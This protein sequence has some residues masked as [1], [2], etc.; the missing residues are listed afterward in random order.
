[1]AKYN[2]RLF[3]KSVDTA[4]FSCG[5][6]ELD[7]YICRYASQDLKRNLARVFIATPTDDSAQLAG[8]YTLSAGSVSC[9]EIPEALAKTLPKYPVPVALLGRLAINTR[10]QTQGL[11]AILLADA[12]QKVAKASAT[13]AVA[14]IIVD[15]KDANGESFYQHFGFIPLPGKAGWLL[16]PISA[17][18]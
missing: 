7:E 18:K 11:G 15:A 16:L 12:C 8:F 5:K 4:S 10:F 3:D 9:T 2:I 13:L 1:M 14:G 17:F 6:P